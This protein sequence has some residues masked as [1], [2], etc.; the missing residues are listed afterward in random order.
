MAPRHAFTLIELLIVVSIIALLALIAVPN[1]LEAQVRA[2]IARVRNDMRA[3]AT[4]LEAYRTEYDGYPDF[5]DIE[6]FGA[7]QM[8]A[9]TT[10][11]AFIATLPADPFLPPIAPEPFTGRRTSFRYS[12]YPI[13]PD[14]AAFWS[15]AS[16]GP[17]LAPDSLGVYRGLD[18]NPFFGRD[19]VMPRWV[20]YDATN[21][22]I[23]VGDLFRANDF[24]P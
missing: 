9:L 20:L 19:P 1:L 8:R 13:L 24:V 17:D 2:K 11:Q 15:L 16:N 23:S 3:L 21:G 10:P 7:L 6:A 4:A 22:T 5:I 12:S 18:L 14:P